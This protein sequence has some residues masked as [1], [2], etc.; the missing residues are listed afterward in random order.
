MW[1]LILQDESG[2]IRAS[3][4]DDHAKKFHPMIEEGKVYYVSHAQIKNIRN[5][6]FNTTSHKY[7]LGLNQNTVVVECANARGVP[8]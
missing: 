4:F 8:R 5:P 3:A 2:D 1:N 6:A 7:E